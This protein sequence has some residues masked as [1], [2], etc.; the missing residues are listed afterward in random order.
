MPLPQ[1]ARSGHGAFIGRTRS[2]TEN[3]NDD[4]QRLEYLGDAAL[5]LAVDYYLYLKYPEMQEGAL[6][7]LA[8]VTPA[9]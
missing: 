7:S 4:N 3:V 2:E 8:V 5:G 9:V 6:T 1:S